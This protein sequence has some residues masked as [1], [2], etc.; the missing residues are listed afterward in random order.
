MTRSPLATRLQSRIQEFATTRV[1]V[2]GDVAIDEMIYGE[3]AR[4]SREAPVLILKHQKTDILL[5]AAGNAAHN[6][7]RLGAETVYVTGVTGDDA[8][9]QHLLE[10]LVRDGIDPK[11]M[12]ADASRPTTT[13]SRIS[14]QARQ[15]VR[16]QIVRIDRESDT[17]VSGT[18]EDRILSSLEELA[19]TCQA[20]LLS[21]YN[22]GVITPRVIETC[23][24]LA[25]THG[26]IWAVDSQ[27]PL[28]HFRGATIATP[29]QPEAEQNVGTIFNTPA[30]VEA[31]GR[32]I[33]DQAGLENLL[34]TLGGEG[35]CLFESKTQAIH[36]IPVFNKSEVF[37]VTGAGDT[38]VATLTLAL[39]SGASLLEASILG[40]L[41][42]SLVVRHYG[43]ATT[44]PEELIATIDTIDWAN[45]LPKAEYDALVALVS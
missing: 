29:N 2:V 5:G 18:I 7:S 22:L 41:A 45:L 43:T 42:A 4:L 17:P 20:I 6:L 21:D 44:S 25:K 1:L 8:Y 34:I 26:L 13:K 11:G 15:S 33:L 36:H 37:D 27:R 12:V 23:R 28:T 24:R 30:D 40:N 35:M 3:T 16:Q 39:A 31:G 10:A 19:P 9:R 14:G 38:V 32:Q